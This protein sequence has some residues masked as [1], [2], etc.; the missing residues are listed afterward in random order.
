VLNH[1]ISC[2]H[3]L[4]PT[5]HYGNVFL[6]IQHYWSAATISHLR[7]PKPWLSLFFVRCFPVDQATCTLTRYMKTLAH[8]ALLV[9][10]ISAVPAPAAHALPWPPKSKLTRQNYEKIHNGMTKEQVE[11]I[12]GRPKQMKSEAEVQGIGKL[13]S[14][15]Y[16]RRRTMVVIG[17]TNG[18]VSDESWTEG[19]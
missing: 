19:W 17:F 4:Q 12:L 6:R 1:E 2:N 10:L 13:E 9:V 15:I 16:W 3:T 7:S 11:E 14:W 8:L 18:Y 5:A